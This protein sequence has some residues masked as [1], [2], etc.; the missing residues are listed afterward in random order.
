MLT[1]IEPRGFTLAEPSHSDVCR[2]H[3][4]FLAAL[5]EHHELTLHR[6]E[7]SYRCIHESKRLLHDT[8]TYKPVD[9]QR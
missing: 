5:A 3:R 9:E 4:E 2:R 7:L 1:T 6:L 8:Q